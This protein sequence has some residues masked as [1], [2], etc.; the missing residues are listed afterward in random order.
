M[1]ALTAGQLRGHSGLI[2]MK[3]SACESLGCFDSRV[4]LQ[5]GI[6]MSITNL[7]MRSGAI[8]GKLPSD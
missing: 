4:K 2:S 5:R 1:V 3:R 6:C 8:E 7:I